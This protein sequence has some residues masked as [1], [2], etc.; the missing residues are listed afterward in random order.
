MAIAAPMDVF[1]VYH[2]P[3]KLIHGTWEWQTPSTDSLLGVP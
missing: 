2:D 3:E 1:I